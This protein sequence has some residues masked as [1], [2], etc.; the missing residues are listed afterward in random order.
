MIKILCIISYR[1]SVYSKEPIQLLL[2]PNRYTFLDLPI[3]TV[4][5]VIG[6]IV[7]PMPTYIEEG[8]KEPTDLKYIS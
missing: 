3:Y 6:I 7:L 1:I 4:V 8:T 5:L 2:T